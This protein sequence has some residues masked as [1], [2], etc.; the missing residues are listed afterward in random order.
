M[1]VWNVSRHSIWANERKIH[2]DTVNFGAVKHPGGHNKMYFKSAQYLLNQYK[3]LRSKLKTLLVLVFWASC[4]IR[5]VKINF[6]QAEINFLNICLNLSAFH[7][8]F[9]TIYMFLSDFF[10]IKVILLPLLYFSVYI[11]YYSFFC[12]VYRIN[13]ILHKC[14]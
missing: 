7:R 6:A 4:Y 1:G 13:L 10:S 2:D 12:A 3:S 9:F 14:I 8:L 5:K 11:V